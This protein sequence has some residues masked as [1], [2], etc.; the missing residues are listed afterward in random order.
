MS[1]ITA[2]IQLVCRGLCTVACLAGCAIG[3][4]ALV[5]WIF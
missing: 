3:I 4:Y 1:V 5:I 2:P